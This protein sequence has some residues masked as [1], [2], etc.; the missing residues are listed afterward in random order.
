[1][2]LE[3]KHILTSYLVYD[4]NEHTKAKE[5]KK[6]VINRILKFNDF[7]NCQFNNEFILKPQQI[8]K[9]EAH[10]EY[11]EEINK[12]ELNINDDKTLQTFGRFIK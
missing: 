9:R 11:T 3:Q 5:T 10:M 8:F 4:G 12:V 6:N 1:M 2:H 7:K